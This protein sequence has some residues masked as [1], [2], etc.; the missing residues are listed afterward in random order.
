MRDQPRSD[1]VFQRAEDQ[2]ELERLRRIEQVVDPASRRRLSGTGLS[3]GWCCLEVG[4]GAGSIMKWM[5]K[6]VG[7]TEQVVAVDLSTKFLADQADQ[8]GSN[9]EIRQDDIRTAVFPPRSFDLVHA[10]YVLIHI[11]NYEVVL[12]RMLDC[13]KPGGWIVIEEPDFSSSRGITGTEE[14]LRSVRKVNQAIERMYSGLGMDFKIGLNLPSLLQRRGL[15][16]LTVDHDVP[17]SAGG[18]GM[19]MIMRLSAVQ[20]REK[21]LATVSSLSRILTGIVDSR[22][23][24]RPGQ[25]TTPRLR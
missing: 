17:L 5:S 21:Y 9:V 2:K 1:Y 13:L 12:D 25:S 4:P 18:S 11:P 22:T 20:L 15:Q 16:A 6:E 3:A 19:A 14:A 7:P 24:V 8:N 23:T 10:R